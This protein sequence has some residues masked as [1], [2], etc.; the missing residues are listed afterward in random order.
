MY[1]AH[2]R[3]RGT[4][5]SHQWEFCIE[6]ALCYLYVQ[7]GIKKLEFA[8]PRYAT[9]EQPN[10]AALKNRML[11][12]VD[13]CK[14][15]NDVKG[16]CVQQMMHKEECVGS[17][18]WILHYESAG[19]DVSCG[20]DLVFLVMPLTLWGDDEWEMFSSCREH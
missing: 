4:S 7:Q 9:N 8:I 1:A 6:I 10:E 16:L 15:A 20:I 19:V 18:F 13:M 17:V 14:A 2:K 3:K 12:I 5:S 11:Y